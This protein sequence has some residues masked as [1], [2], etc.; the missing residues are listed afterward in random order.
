MEVLDRGD[1]T[2]IIDWMPHGRAFIVKQPK[3]FTTQVLPRFFKQTKF[4]SFTRQ[5][6][7]WGFKRIT[8]GLD[9]GAYYHELFLP[10]RRNLS[11]RMRRQK[12]KG[13]GIRP[14]PNPGAEP[15]F[16]YDYPHVARVPRSGS[17]IPLPPLPSERIANL[18]GE[19][20]QVS[21]QTASVEKTPMPQQT[22]PFLSQ[23]HPLAFSRG[24]AQPP[25]QQLGGFANLGGNRGGFSARP[26]GRGLGLGMSMNVDDLSSIAPSQNTISAAAAAE[27]RL[28]GSM[29]PGIPTS[30]SS[31][32]SRIM[33]HHGLP[34]GISSLRPDAHMHSS[35][36]FDHASRYLRQ[37]SM[38][39]AAPRSFA[40]TNSDTAH[41]EV[42]N[43][44]R[45]L[46]QR[47]LEQTTSAP[48]PPDML[49]HHSLL[50]GRQPSYQI[51][52]AASILGRGS[53]VM[54]PRP[55]APTPARRGSFSPQQQTS[56]T[57]MF[58]TDYG[59][60]SNDPRSNNS[61]GSFSA[62]MPPVP[63]RSSAHSA[64]IATVTNALREAQR[65]EEMA[66]TQR[67]AAKTLAGALQERMGGQDLTLSLGQDFQQG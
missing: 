51:S 53:S 7:L 61:I 26:M 40:P 45:R 27:H 62:S 2:S 39:D 20:E 65:L 9:A 4:L 8:R 50:T 25:S 66:R 44:N 49:G 10:G 56:S 30:S 15:N 38:S 43:A 64:D 67:A 18:M 54:T 14:M 35:N 55:V 12:I 22:Q 13:T 33:A 21:D 57:Y 3:I 5:L 34:L 52:D 46:M 63:L 23:G 16:Y 60:Y 29:V 37:A 42:S 48:A 36:T 59:S 28:R 41:D 31:S 24:L 11:M 58:P 17:P 1:L 19:R 47:L 32:A 6:N